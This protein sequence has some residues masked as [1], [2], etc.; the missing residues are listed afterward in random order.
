MSDKKEC[1]YTEM[2]KVR[3]FNTPYDDA[4]KTLITESR[5][6]IIPLI[7]ELFSENYSGNEEVVQVSNEFY[8]HSDNTDEKV[9][10]DSVFIIAGSKQKN[11]HIEMQ[12]APDGTMLIRMYRYDSLIAVTYSE[13]D[14]NE[15]TV[16]FP[17]SAVIYLSGSDSIPEYSTIR[18]ETSRGFMVH[19][20]RNMKIKDYSVDELFNKRLY[21][22]IPFHLF[23]YEGKFSSIENNKQEYNELVEHYKTIRERLEMAAEVGEITGADKSVVTEMTDK[24]IQALAFKHERIKEGLGGVMGGEYIMSESRKSYLRGKEEGKSEGIA[25]GKLYALSSLVDEGILTVEDAARRAGVTVEEFVKQ[26][27]ILFIAQESGDD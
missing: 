18:I 24:V 5:Q 16:K 20:I 11:Y 22:L 17:Q 12:R 3:P 2:D 15:L 8:I 19:E 21:L 1:D 9:A 25:Q 27:D 6:L 23:T 13:F 10:T 7:N 26:R 14:G 4:Y